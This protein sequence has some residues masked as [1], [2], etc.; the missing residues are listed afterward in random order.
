MALKRKLKPDDIR[1]FQDTVYNYYRNNP[2][3]LPWRETYNPYHILVSEIMLQQTHVERVIQKYH[4]FLHIFP[5]F[6]ALACTSLQKALLAWQGLG[7]NRR[8]VALHETARMVV[9]DYK[10]IL[11]SE[12]EV[13]QS[14]P[15]IGSYTARAIAAF[16]F[17]KPVVFVETNIRSIFIHFFFEKRTGIKD[18]DILP[19]VELVLDRENPREWYYALMDYGVMIKKKYPN[20]GRKSA[21]YQK[22]SPF[23][24]SDRQIR[25]AVIRK[26]TSQIAI[27]V[28]E[29]IPTLGFNEERTQRIIERLEKEGLVRLQNGLVSIL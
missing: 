7:Y 21:H 6:E 4:D 10:G 3:K 9:T 1:T 12:P 16:A 17:N 29:L 27:P 22:Q 19:L 25:G 23:H 26:L 13:L 11:P 8:A 15:G 14:F 5:D 24:G 28:H 20:P 18:C 2:R